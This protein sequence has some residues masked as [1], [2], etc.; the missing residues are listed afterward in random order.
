MKLA[1]IDYG[2]CNLLSIHN[3][4]KYLNVDC[5]IT[6]NGDEIQGAD[7]VILPGVGAFEDGMDGLRSKHLICAVQDFVSTGK[8]FLG[9]CLGMQMLMSKGFEFGEFD[10]LGLIP[11]QV[12]R[13]AH[14]A[15][16]EGRSLKIPHV[17][18]NGL[19]PAVQPWEGSILGGLK[20]GVEMY[21]VHSYC[22]FPDNASDILAE[23]TYGTQKF[24]S[25]VRRDNVY[26][27]QFHPEKSSRLG[28]NILQNFVQLKHA[29]N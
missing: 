25:V 28:L 2:L 11:G 22:V 18:W 7:A 15:L 4:L 17:S 13:F 19:M 10:G 3:A 26:G 8:P 29:L 6:S 5:T 12:R 14:E 1:V 9:I 20:P 24:C 16:P 23:T 27:C 21:F